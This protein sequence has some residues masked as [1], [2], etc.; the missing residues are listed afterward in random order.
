MNQKRMIGPN[1]SVLLIIVLSIITCGIYPF[2]WMYQVTSELNEYT[3]DYHLN[4]SLVIVLTLLTCG[5]YQFY[6]WYRI[7]ELMM[8]AQYQTGY[9]M[10]TD[11]KLLFILLTFFGLAL[12]NM[13]ILQS[14]LNRLWDQAMRADAEVNN[15]PPIDSTSNDEWTDY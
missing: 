7:N 3:E 1:R 13:A 10:P 14:D 6:W 5:L 2:I 12:I 11:N 15:Q 8:R 4:P 9:S